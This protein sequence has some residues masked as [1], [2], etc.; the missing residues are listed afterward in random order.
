MA[1]KLKLAEA[2]VDELYRVENSAGEIEGVCFV[3]VHDTGRFDPHGGNLY[4]LIVRD[5]EGYLFAGEFCSRF[6]R[7]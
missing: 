7:R 5:S 6:R 2:T 3:V 1:K 4:L